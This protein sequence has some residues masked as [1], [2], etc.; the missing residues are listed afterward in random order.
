MLFRSQDLAI[1]DPRPFSSDSINSWNKSEKNPS[2]IDFILIQPFANQ[3]IMHK[4]TIIRPR[5]LYKGQEMDLADHYGV[6]C[7]LIVR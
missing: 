4:Q 7:E 3:I 1:S 2:Q 6:L 5:R